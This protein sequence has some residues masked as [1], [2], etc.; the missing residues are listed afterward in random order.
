MSTT[1]RCS[2]TEEMVRDHRAENGVCDRC[3]GIAWPR[4]EASLSQAQPVEENSVI[5]RA[6][7]VQKVIAHHED[8]CIASCD[9]K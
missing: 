4:I 8:E 1:L 2:S 5:K 6:L 9:H 7:F 3:I